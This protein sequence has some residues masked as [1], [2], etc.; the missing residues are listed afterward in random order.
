MTEYEFKFKITIV[1]DSYTGKTNIIKKYFQNS[2]E[3]DSRPTVGVEF[4]S[5]ILNINGKIIKIEVW[6]TA[7]QERYKSITTAYYKGAKCCLIVYD[8]TNKSSFDNIDKRIKEINNEIQN[9]FI[10][11]IG[12][13][14]DLNEKREVSIEEAL[15]KAEKYNCDFYEISVLLM[16]NIL[17]LFL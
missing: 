4:C 8:I 15:Q 10:I 7:G 17:I 5:K 2:F 14:S 1:G 3:E 11:L 13:K 9:P 6:D 12:N 16:E